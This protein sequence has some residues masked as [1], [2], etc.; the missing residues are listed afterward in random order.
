MVFHGNR[1]PSGMRKLELVE[2][3]KKSVTGLL[4]VILRTAQIAKPKVIKIFWD[5]ASLPMRLQGRRLALA[6]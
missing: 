1:K 3:T 6:A 5:A 4:L 2:Q